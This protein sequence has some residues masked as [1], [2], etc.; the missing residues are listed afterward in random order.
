MWKRWRYWRSNHPAFSSMI[1]GHASVAAWI[2]PPSA[3]PGISPTR[4]EISWN[5]APQS[6][7][8]AAFAGNGSCG[9]R[10]RRM[11]LLQRF[12]W[13]RDIG[14][15]LISPRV[16]EMSGRTEGGEPH[17]QRACL[18]SKQKQHLKI[19]IEHHHP[20][21]WSV[22]LPVTPSQRQRPPARPSGARQV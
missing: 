5:Q 6:K 9:I 19:S 13:D 18:P 17:T 8:T 7:S 2:Y 4:G 14:P 3:L 12:M 16:G 22:P 10:K 1:A 21:G 20:A 11:S 15:Q